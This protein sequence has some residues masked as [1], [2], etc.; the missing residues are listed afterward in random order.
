MTITLN[1]NYLQLFFSTRPFGTPYLY[2]IVA[3]LIINVIALSAIEIKRWIEYVKDLVVPIHNFNNVP[4][5][6]SIVTFG[7]VLSYLFT[8]LM[9]Q[10]MT[11]GYRLLYPSQVGFT[12][13]FFQIREIALWLINDIFVPVVYFAHNS[14][15]RSY[16]KDLLVHL[17]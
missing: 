8:M 17:G 14:N 4:I 10:V 9:F 16:V 3:C 5:N 7:Q 15:F 13:E 12:Y 6:K 11:Q 1:L 2:F